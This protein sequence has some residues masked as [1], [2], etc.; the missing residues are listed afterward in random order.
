MIHRRAALGLMAGTAAA[1]AGCGRDDGITRLT[2]WAMG[3]E[4][5]NVPRLIPAFEAANPGIKV[6]VQP[7]PWSAAHQKLLTAY[8]GNS[9]PDVSQ[10]GNTWVA[11]MAAIG[12]LSPLPGAAAD[13]LTDQFPAVLDTN[14]IDGRVVATPW[15]VDTRLIFHRTDL[16]AQAGYATLPMTW[17]EW[18]AAMHAVRRIVGPDKYAI[19]LPLMDRVRAWLVQLLLL[20]PLD[21]RRHEGPSP[22]GDSTPL[23]HSRCTGAHRSRRVGAWRIVAGGLPLLAEPRGGVEAGSL[24]V[25]SGGAGRVQCHDGKP[26]GPAN[27]LGGSQGRV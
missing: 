5:T 16:L 4:G 25:R 10:I 2:F 6:E 14:R 15:Y 21:H 12:A 19:L 18:K 1:L 20:R 3:N 24:P 11:E 27:G 9:L 8:V 26:A 23:D 22:A 7:Q 13:L 17:I